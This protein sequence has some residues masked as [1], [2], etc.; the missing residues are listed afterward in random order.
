MTTLRKLFLNATE[1]GRS[2]SVVTT[3]L[4]LIK[5]LDINATWQ[6]SK[7]R[8][9]MRSIQSEKPDKFEE[10]G[11]FQDESVDVIQCPPNLINEAFG[12]RRERI[13]MFQEL[14]DL[15]IT[16]DEI[17]QCTTTTFSV[18]LKALFMAETRL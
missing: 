1:E 16:V 10:K 14:L 18:S 7:F 5:L 13:P 15:Q 17:I 8:P 9:S 12:A 11:I 4:Q 6:F 3:L 2:V